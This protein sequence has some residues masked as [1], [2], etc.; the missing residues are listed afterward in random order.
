MYKHI[1]YK[2]S[3]TNLH[4]RKQCI[5]KDNRNTISEARIRYLEIIQGIVLRM[6]NNSFTLKGWA[7]T[8]TSA[9][10]GV[11]ALNK[12]I[13]ATYICI[14][15]FLV[16]I[17]FIFLDCHFLSH[18]RIYRNLYDKV[19]K[20]NG[21]LDFNVMDLNIHKSNNTTK[22]KCACS[23][24]I[25]FFY[26]SMLIAIFFSHPY[27]QNN[28]LM[29]LHNI[30][31]FIINVVIYFIIIIFLYFI[32]RVTKHY[33]IKNKGFRNIKC[34]YKKKIY[35]K[36]NNIYNSRKITRRRSYGLPS[37]ESI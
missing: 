36:L 13:N 11:I 29:E 4:N 9:A 37:N 2:A 33:C 18:E 31:Y 6:S 20:Q 1:S 15:S 19:R 16:N 27:I 26:G 12:D 21:P 22:R 5:I 28:I 25:T 23:K 24:C 32:Y 17:S 30:I 8:L 14:I 7:I 10:I 34:I 35:K 3:P